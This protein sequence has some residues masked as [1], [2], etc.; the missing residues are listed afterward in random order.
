MNGLLA[1][2]ERNGIINADAVSRLK[3]YIYRKHA[4]LSLERRAVILADALNRAIDVRLPR[5]E[6]ALF[7]SLKGRLLEHAV[8]R[9]LFEI[10]CSD[11]FLAAMD[12]KETGEGFYNDLGDWILENLT[13][14]VSKK[15]LVELVQKVHRLTG[16]GMNTAEAI[17]EAE[18]EAALDSIETVADQ[19]AAALAAVTGTGP[20]TTSA[21]ASACVTAYPVKTL[22]T[23]ALTRPRRSAVLA[24]AVALFLFGSPFLLG[25]DHADNREAKPVLGQVAMNPVNSLQTGDEQLGMNEE[26]L[27]DGE[28]A[29]RMLK[30]KATA[31]DLSV[32]SCGKHPGEPG[33]GIT[34]SGTK[35][36]AG[37]T[38]AVDPE[39]VPLGSRLHI[40]F[41]DEYSH[42]D[43]IYIAEDTG[44]LIKGNTVDI[45]FG[46]DK[47]GSTEI[48]NQAMKFGVRYVDV[49][50]L[51]DGEG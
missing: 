33:Y 24:A 32:G 37:R 16:S 41:P 38:V 48:Y 21:S 50:I 22:V 8:K 17:R 14:K 4:D 25:L 6:D 3:G 43:G 2:L 10:F 31:Y 45:F 46:E 7:K 20:L 39:V 47:S 28:S 13:E 42:L 12:L 19:P 18:A 51:D 35:A 26:V 44:R 15:E 29:E 11:V 49:T 9:P 1:D 5:L 27:Q 36:K 34:S 40:T 23:A 30:M